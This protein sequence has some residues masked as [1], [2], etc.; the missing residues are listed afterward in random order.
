MKSRYENRVGYSRRYEIS[1]VPLA[2][3]YVASS[4]GC[5]F[6]TISKKLRQVGSDERSGRSIRSHVRATLSRPVVSLTGRPEV[7]FKV[8]KAR[9]SSPLAIWTRIS[10][11]LATEVR[12]VYDLRR[13]RKKE[14]KRERER[15]RERERKG[16]CMVCKG[17]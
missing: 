4:R 8:K 3:S 2:I 1:R 6:K 9:V 11:E 7:V 14:R 16:E 5:N 17:L 12:T 13:E 15:E 10:I